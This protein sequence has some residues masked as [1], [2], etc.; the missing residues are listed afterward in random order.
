MCIV[1]DLRHRSNPIRCM[2]VRLV[3]LKQL[4]MLPLCDQRRAWTDAGIII[5]SIRKQ[6]HPDNTRTRNTWKHTSLVSKTHKFY[7][8]WFIAVSLVVRYIC[9]AQFLTKAWSWNMELNELSPE[10][11]R[12]KSMDIYTRGTEDELDEWKWW[13]YKKIRKYVKNMRGIEDVLK[14]Q[15]V[16][17]G[18]LECK[19]FTLNKRV[20]KLTGGGI[21]AEREHDESD[22]KWNMRLTY[23]GS[24]TPNPIC[25]EG[26][27]FSKHMRIF[28]SGRSN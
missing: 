18:V 7:N 9:T 3:W 13:I 21:H 14:W 26:G 1:Y 10:E 15:T 12:G 17:L 11:W 4:I 27:S 20:G 24:L 8:M 16:K 28:C 22:Q 25:S 5:S 23:I 6:P 19:K 2:H